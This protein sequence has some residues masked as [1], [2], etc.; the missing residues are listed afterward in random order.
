MGA[1]IVRKIRRV[2]FMLKNINVIWVF[3]FRS[4]EGT[5]YLIKELDTLNETEAREKFV[6][7][8][9][10]RIIDCVVRQVALEDMP[11]IILVLQSKNKEAH[12]VM[13]RA[14]Y[15]EKFPTIGI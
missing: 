4:E 6:S 7:E 2:L 11:L 5:E 8:R 3:E 9:P 10:E 15:L 14:L 12:R 1:Y 13:A